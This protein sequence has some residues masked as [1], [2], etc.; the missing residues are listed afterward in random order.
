MSAIP[1]SAP[2]GWYPDSDP[3][4][5]RYWDGSAWTQEVAAVTRGPA[6]A[7]RLLR[8]RGLSKVLL[9]VIAAQVIAYVVGGAFTF[10]TE[11]I[12]ALNA[13]LESNSAAL[14]VA[15]AV[16]IVAGLTY[17]A[18]LPLS[19]VLAMVWTWDVRVN[20]EALSPYQ[21]TRA[22]FWA[23]AGWITPIVCFWFPHQVLQDV[24]RA[25]KVV[26]DSTPTTSHP[27]PLAA[28]WSS[29]IAYAVI[30]WLLSDVDLDLPRYLDWLGFW[31][32][33]GAA[34]IAFILFRRIVH[35]IDGDQASIASGSTRDR[36]PA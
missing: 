7:R 17:L 32:C 18:A 23:W 14:D 15:S 6:P 33:A 24:D 28:W 10:L 5:L 3:R 2:P 11:S 25:D 35:T 9:A 26:L 4:Q 30:S 1:V 31:L 27:A 19:G 34:V 29:F 12:P 21:H 20:A 16:V 22:R 36:P 13:Y 8:T